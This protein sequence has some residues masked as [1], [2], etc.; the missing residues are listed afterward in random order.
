MN[1][2]YLKFLEFLISLIDK[3]NKGLIIK[4]LRSK[5]LDKSIIAFDVGAHK[6][7]TLEIFIKHFNIRNIFCFEPNQIIYQKLKKKIKNKNYKNV[8]IFNC[9]LGNKTETRSLKTFSDTSSS[10]FSQVDSKSNYYLRKKK[11]FDLFSN[12]FFSKNIDAEVITFSEF[13]EKYKIKKIDILKIDTEGF[14][15]KVLK[16]IKDNDFKN[17]ELVYFEHHYDLMLKKGYKFSDINKLLIEK[18]FKMVF[19]IKMKFRK[20]FEYIYELKKK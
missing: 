19:K 11:V 14:E 13:V 5:T 10:T 2:L 12:N 15:Y 17:I 9:G 1:N 6:G 18:N 7:E 20:T 8:S 3:P 16:G 4:F